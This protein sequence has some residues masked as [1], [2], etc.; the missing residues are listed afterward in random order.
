MGTDLK[1]LK[2]MFFFK[3]ILTSTFVYSS[4]GALSDKKTRVLHYAKFD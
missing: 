1:M 4:A 2:N 3:A